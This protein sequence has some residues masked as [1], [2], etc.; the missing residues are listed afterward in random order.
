MFGQILKLK[1]RYPRQDMEYVNLHSRFWYRVVA[2]AAT[3][4]IFAV[5]VYV[6]FQVRDIAR[7]LGTIAGAAQACVAEQRP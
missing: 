5:A 7:D 2:G 6:G 3:A 4:G 1:D